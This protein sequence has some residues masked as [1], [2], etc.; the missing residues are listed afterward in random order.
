MYSGN[1]SITPIGG[2]QILVTFALRNGGEA[3]YTYSGDEAAAILERDDK[4]NRQY[5]E[6]GEG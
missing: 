3:S 4:K 2:G 6:S 1:A 5:D